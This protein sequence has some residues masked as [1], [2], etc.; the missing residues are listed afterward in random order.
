MKHTPLIATI[1][2]T[3]LASSVATSVLAVAP[4]AS[5]SATLSPKPTDAKSKQIEDLKDRLATKVA[6]LR[7]TRTSALFGT[8]SVTTVSTISIGTKTKDIKMDIPDDLRVFQVLKGKRTTLTSDAVT[9][10]DVITV[11]GDLDTTL[12]VMKP[13]VIFI[14][15]ILPQLIH[16]TITNIDKTAYTI[17]VLSPDNMTYTIDIEQTTKILVNDKDKGLIKTGFSKIAI[18]DV[19]H[20]VGAPEPKKENQLSGVRILDLGALTAATTPVL[21]PTPTSVASPSATPVV[22]KVKSTPTPAETK[23]P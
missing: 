2:G 6:E 1:I 10:G 7:Q 9:K 8:V 18:G 22:K 20:V 23:T 11:F 21:S 13:K 15:P 5:P 16:G 19:V 4:V 12:D 14:E 17:T 3:L